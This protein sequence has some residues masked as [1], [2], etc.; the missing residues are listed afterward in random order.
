MALLRLSGAGTNSSSLYPLSGL[1]RK[2]FKVS[3]V[4]KRAAASPSPASK[5][6][7][8]PLFTPLQLREIVKTLDAGPD[9]PLQILAGVLFPKASPK[10][11]IAAYSE[12]ADHEKHKT[13]P[14]KP[15]AEVTF[16]K[17]ANSIQRT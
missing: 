16:P 1:D 14:L 15:V 2:P 12:A 6:P 9:A 17:T 4:R 5:V 8:G 10:K 3:A 7:T 13:E 11:A